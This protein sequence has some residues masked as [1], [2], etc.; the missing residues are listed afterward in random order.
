MGQRQKKMGST[1][2][3][4]VLP[5]PPLTWTSAGNDALV[6][7]H[8]RGQPDRLE[9]CQHTHTAVRGHPAVC[10]SAHSQDASVPVPY[11][12]LQESRTRELPAH[13]LRGDALPQAGCLIM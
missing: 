11:L 3:A 13:P 7:Q 9:T 8:A 10:S 4:I 6:S 1:S 2:R 12:C 5:C